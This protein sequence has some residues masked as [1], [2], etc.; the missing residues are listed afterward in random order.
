M[1]IELLTIQQDGFSTAFQQRNQKSSMEILIKQSNYI[2]HSICIYQ[3]M[4]FVL[5][6][7]CYQH[8]LASPLRNAIFFTF[9]H[10]VI[11]FLFYMILDALANKF[12][13]QELFKEED[14]VLNIFELNHSLIFLTLQELLSFF[15]PMNGIVLL[16]K[17]QQKMFKYPL[18]IIRILYY[19]TSAYYFIQLSN[20]PQEQSFL[21]ME[22]ILELIISWVTTLI[23][24]I[25]IG[26]ILVINITLGKQIGF[27]F[28]NRLQQSIS[29]KFTEIKFQD[30]N[31]SIKACNLDCPIC[32]EQINDADTIIQLPCHQK[33]LF[34][35][36]CCKQW[37]FQDLRCP[38]CR[39]E[40]ECNAKTNIQ[41]ELETS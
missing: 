17:I 25:S 29:N 39:N 4:K 18:T 9:M 3:I 41:T 33:H 40:L 23:I 15:R 26:V 6:L 27:R 16:Y 5:F 7:A 24:M 2:C 28:Q 36:Q 30:L 20:S 13:Y 38:L 12:S 37:L 34:H 14:Q 31:Q 21:I 11:T 35:S 8:T 22:Q 1:D 19:F 32:Y 10:D